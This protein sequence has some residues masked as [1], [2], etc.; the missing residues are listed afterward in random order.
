MTQLKATDRYFGSLCVIHNSEKYSFR[1]LHTVF[2][3]FPNLFNT[4]PRRVSCNT[5]APAAFSIHTE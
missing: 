2:T 5:C 3:C 1:V 4:F